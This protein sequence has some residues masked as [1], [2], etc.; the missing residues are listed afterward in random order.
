MHPPVFGISKSAP[1][2]GLK[3]DGY[4][5]P[6]NT[7]LTVSVFV[8]AHPILKSVVVGDLNLD[9]YNTM[10]GKSDVI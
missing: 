2:A 10:P 1:A 3:V 6:A 5:I 7:M 9:Y 4:H 8:D